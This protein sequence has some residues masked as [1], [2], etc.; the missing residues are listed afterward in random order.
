MSTDKMHADEV[1][2]DAALVR[3][4]LAAQFPHWA[5]LP[6]EPFPS[7]GTAN[8]IYRLGDDKAVR[9][10]RRAAGASVIDKEREWLP[11]LGPLLPL[12]V[13]VPLSQGEPAEGYPLRWSIHGW[14]EGESATPDRIADPH[15]A[16]TDLAG[17]IRALRQ[18]DPAG[19]P[20]GL[21]RG[22]PL[23]GR[24]EQI[25]LALRALD[26]VIDTPVAAAMWDGA[27]RVPEWTGPPTWF[28]SDLQPGNLLAREGRLCAV[29]DFAGCGVGDPACDLIV[30]WGL[31]PAEVREVF[32]A[33]LD[34]D[35]AMWARGRGWALFM[36]LVGLPYYLDTNPS[37]VRFLRHLLKE[38]LAEGS[39]G[40]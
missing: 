37:F 23:S 25:Q 31:L 27:V 29:I 13:P 4:L 28:H 32:R 18:I 9:M 26:G 6:I 36:G 14:L 30:A 39:G 20:T 1:P 34:V 22:L 33:A 16:A 15:Q 24:D 19:G 12:A 17:F 10:P 35:D 11:K 3:R 21:A 8:K 40:A 38:V 2:T 5:D 7:G